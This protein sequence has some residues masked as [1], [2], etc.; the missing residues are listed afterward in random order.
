VDLIRSIP[1]FPIMRFYPILH[2]I[3]YVLNKVQI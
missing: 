3:P 1:C 2:P